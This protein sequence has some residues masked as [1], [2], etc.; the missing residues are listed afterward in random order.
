MSGNY[1]LVIYIAE[2]QSILK[3]SKPEH[4]NCII[5]YNC[6][7]AILKSIDYFIKLISFESILL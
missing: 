7:C 2:S 4:K 6:F 5:S 1:L 3:E